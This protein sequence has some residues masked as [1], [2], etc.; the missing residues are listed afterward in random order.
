MLRAFPGSDYYESSANMRS[1]EECLFAS[2]HAF[3]C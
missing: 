2:A 1:I 3:P